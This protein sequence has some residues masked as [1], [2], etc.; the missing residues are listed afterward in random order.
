M[1]PS[2][3]T[4]FYS[5]GPALPAAAGGAARR[6][7]SACRWVGGRT[8][9]SGARRGVGR[10]RARWGVGVARRRGPGGRLGGGECVEGRGAAGAGA[11]AGAGGGL[12]GVLAHGRLGGAGGEHGGGG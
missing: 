1:L 10:R 7:S 2:A 4:S 3:E 6:E 12:G 11:G 8:P 5:G 9:G